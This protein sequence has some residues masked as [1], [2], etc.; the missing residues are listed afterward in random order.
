M[1][2]D[3]I[4]RRADVFFQFQ[5]ILV[6][7]A[8]ANAGAWGIPAGEV[9]A[10]T[11]ASAAYEA[12]YHTA[13]N[14]LT[15]TKPANQTHQMERKKLEKHLRAFVNAWLAGNSAISQP[16]KT[17]MGLNDR[18]HKRHKRPQIFDRPALNLKPIGSGRLKVSCRLPQSEGKPRLHPYADAIEIVYHTGS[19]PGTPEQCSG[20]H[21]SKK[22]TFVMDVGMQHAGK[23]IFAFARYI[24]IQ[25]MSKSSGFSDYTA[26]MVG[27]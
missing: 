24:N 27:L 22:S 14:V 8:S 7:K 15:R 12:S 19:N 5:K 21:I 25:D 23:M 3:Y 16:E 26:T 2:K 18:S 9:A 4:P 17:G 13:T 20:R 10:L 11:A 6:Q 1:A